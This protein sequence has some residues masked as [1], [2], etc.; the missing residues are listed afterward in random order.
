[1]YVFEK[2]NSGVKWIIILIYMVDVRR[3]RS[4]DLFLV[5]KFGDEILNL[6][7]EEFEDVENIFFEGKKLVLLIYF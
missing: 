1:M 7:V 5:S 6:M 4:E 2:E 3:L